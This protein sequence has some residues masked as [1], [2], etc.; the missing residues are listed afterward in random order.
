MEARKTNST[1]RAAKSAKFRRKKLNTDTFIL[2]RTKNSERKQ[3][4]VRE[5]A[6]VKNLQRH[7]LQ[8]FATGVF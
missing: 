6:R 4:A 5:L 2:T 3:G 1:C 8:F 7:A